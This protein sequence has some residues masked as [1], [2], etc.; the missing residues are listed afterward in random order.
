MA[1]GLSS[2]GGLA[3]TL[4]S[5]AADTEASAKIAS[6]RM[7]NSTRSGF[8]NVSGQ[9][10]QGIDTMGIKLPSGVSGPPRI[11]AEAGGDVEMGEMTEAVAER[12]GLVGSAKAAMASVTGG[13]SSS[14]SSSDAESNWGVTISRSDRFKGFV[15]ML[16]LSGFFFSL[17]AA[18]LPVVLIFPAKFAISFSLGSLFFMTAFALMQGPWEWA[19]VVCSLE[20]LP[21]TVSYFGSI[22]GTLYACMIMKSYLLVVAFSCLQLTALAWYG[23]TYIPGGR[24]GLRYLGMVVR[25]FLSTAFKTCTMCFKALMK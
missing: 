7:M 15:V 14:S 1:S 4:S 5:W 11:A 25:S 8:S 19:K 9:L 22:L 24:N 3:N 23:M 2:V 10:R 6:E 16:V 17:G 20:R 18:F 12:Q 21:F 13:T